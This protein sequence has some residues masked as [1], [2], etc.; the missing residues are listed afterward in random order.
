MKKLLFSTLFFLGFFSWTQAQSTA[1]DWQSDLRFLQTTV[2]S[3]YAF[4]LKKITRKDFDAQIEKLYQDIP[5]LQPHQILVGFSRIV[6]T[7]Q[8]GHTYVA[9]DNKTVKFHRLPV[10]FMQFS[11][12]VYLQAVTRDYPKAVGAKV[13]KMGDMPIDAALKAIYPVVSAENSQFFKAYSADALRTPEILHAQRVLPN[14]TNKIK[15]TLEKEGKIFDQIFEAKETFETDEQYGFFKENKTWLDA[16]NSD[17]TPLYLK[18]LNKMYFFEYLPD[19]KTVYVR[20][21]QIED[22][23]SEDIP[24]FYA[25][26]F[27]FI[28]HNDVEKLVLDVRLNGG[29]NNYKNK[30]IVTSLIKSSKINQKGKFFVILG[31][32]TFSACQ[33]LVNELHNYTNALFVGEPTGE[34]INFY[35]DNRLI[36]LPKTKVP[37][38]LSFAWWQDK[39]EWDNDDWLAP[40]LPVDM[41]FDDYRSNRDPVLDA[42]V[43]F[44]DKNFVIDPMAHLF[45]LFQKGN[46]PM[47]ETET[48]RFSKDSRYR[49][50]NLEA[51]LTQAGGRLLEQNQL[52]SGLYV[53]DLVTRVYPQS[54]KAWTALAKGLEK[55]NQPEK[56]VL[57][58]KKAAD[59]GGKK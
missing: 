24:T 49:Y 50:Q 17:K 26:L 31:A 20:H 53:L 2:H 25:R 38:R 33:N 54:A 51:K 48:L 1:N 47:I 57:A 59:L 8:Y 55:A 15:L 5:T 14:L 10:Q 28:E 40:N 19:S 36:E 13:L 32:R 56:A 18:D 43:R 16:R 12:G 41:S 3:D 11:D 30:A 44:S 27:D 22:D 9:F 23:P 37:V 58:Q 34:N 35:G 46:I 7:L 39:P 21:S 52:Q 45:D 29:G 4:L 42:A 6:A